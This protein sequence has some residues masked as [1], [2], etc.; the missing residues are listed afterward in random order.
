MDVLDPRAHPLQGKIVVL[1][2]C[3][4]I[5]AY[6]AA[7]LTRLLTKAGAEV[8]VVMTRAA[9]EFIRE[10]TFQTL[11]GHPVATD[12]F[13]LGQESEI[14]HIKLA[15][16]ADLVLIAPA[17]ADAIARLAAGMGDDLL[18]TIA[19][20]TKAPLLLA[21][22]MNVNMWEHPIVRANLLRLVEMVKAQ[23]VGPG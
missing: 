3:G 8:R 23:V 16:Q 4:G 21:P 22:S 15:D 9:T 2:V 7:E 18:T 17:T 12:L 1:G 6:K 5:A 10:L 20:A 19:L 13:D 14:G 11:S